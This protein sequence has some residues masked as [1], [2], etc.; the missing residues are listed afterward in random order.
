MINGKITITSVDYEKAF[1]VCS[2]SLYRNVV[3]W[4]IRDLRYF[5]NKIGT[6]SLPVVLKIMRYM[7]DAE[8]EALMLAIIDSNRIQITEA[9]NK[10]LADHDFGTRCKSAISVLLKWKTRKDF[11][12]LQPV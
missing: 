4:R 2:Q 3:P 6:D 9:L 12:W 11:L 10:F 1:R 8:K 5:I 7:S